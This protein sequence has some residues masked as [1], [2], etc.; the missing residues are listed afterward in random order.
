MASVLTW[1]RRRLSGKSS[2][3]V[4]AMIEQANAARDAQRWRTARDLYRNALAVRPERVG[5]WMQ[6]GHMLKHCG[7]LDG[8]VKSYNRALALSPKRADTALQLGHAFK[9]M[10]ELETARDWYIKALIWPGATPHAR[11]ELRS[12]GL[13]AEQIRLLPLNEDE[14]GARGAMDRRSPAVDAPRVCWDV[15]AAFHAVA[16]RRRPFASGEAFARAVAELC[17]VSG[18]PVVFF[19]PEENLFRELLISDLD[20]ALVTL[21]TEGVW[22]APVA[23]PISVAATVLVRNLEEEANDFAPGLIRWRTCIAQAGGYARL[24]KDGRNFVSV[25]EA[26]EWTAPRRAKGD[27]AV[28]RSETFARPRGV[29][30]PQDEIPALQPGLFY[31]VAPRQNELDAEFEAN[32]QPYLWGDGWL[33]RSD[34]G[35]AVGRGAELLI[36][37]FAPRFTPYLCRILWASRGQVSGDSGRPVWT[38]SQVMPDSNSLMLSISLEG[39]APRGDGGDLVIGFTIFPEDCDY[40]WFDL[41]AAAASRR[42]PSVTSLAW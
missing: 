25:S 29:R 36:R 38:T 17:R 12:L 34:G 16:S 33:S 19:D 21:A 10:A 14:S 8:A 30:P 23:K 24:T 3:D 27:D 7:D 37:L 40:Y 9:L 39:L 20:A 32:G 1:V 41:M 13:T 15:S 31:V 11:M 26:L 28:F 6:H 22:S 42:L 2:K 5:L 4:A 35:R 18:E